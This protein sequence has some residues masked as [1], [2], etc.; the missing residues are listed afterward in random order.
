MNYQLFHGNCLEVIPQLIDM[1]I[2]IDAGVIDP[3]Y[4]INGGKGGDS[5]LY[6]KGG[7]N[8]EEWEDTE[9]YIVDV[10]IPVINILRRVC[11][12]VIVTPG[13]RCMHLYP[14]PDDVGC[15]WTP[16][17]VTHGP[18][19]FTS[20]TPILYYGKDWRAGRGPLPSGRSLTESSPQNGHPCPKPIGAW[21]WLVDKAARSGETVIDPFMGSGTTGVACATRKC[22]F[23]GIELDAA[24]FAI[25]QDRIETAYRKAKG[26]P[27][28]GKPSDTADLPLSPEYQN[29]Q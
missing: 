17:S 5:R 6:N 14:R 24:Y 26:L 23:V 8:S 4:G 20:F 27:R 11:R 2:E 29:C 15:F 7:Y 16:A 28:L 21:T 18:W 13:N 25:A 22:N 10:V 12:C 3:P 19:G 9:E 1:E